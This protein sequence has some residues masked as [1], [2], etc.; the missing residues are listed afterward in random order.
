MVLSDR[1]LRSGYT[2]SDILRESIAAETIQ[3]SRE[4]NLKKSGR[5]DTFRK[6][7]IKATKSGVMERRSSA[8]RLFSKSPTAASNTAV[9]TTSRV[10]RNSI[11]PQRSQSRRSLS[12]RDLFRIATLK[13]VAPA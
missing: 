6:V 8:P 1:L 7:L 11:A 9:E 10:R 3:K 4:T 12:T 2:L 5:F 13:Q